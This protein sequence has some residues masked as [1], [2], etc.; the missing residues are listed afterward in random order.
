[1]VFVA[2]M[3]SVS[4]ALGLE[5]RIQTWGADDGLLQNSAADIAQTPEG[6]LIIGSWFGDLVRFDGARF[7]MYDFSGH[8]EW[9]S[10]AISRLLEDDQGNLW[11]GQIERILRYRRG[12]LTAETCA[13]PHKVTIRGWVSPDARRP[14]F[15]LDDGSLL[16][17]DPKASSGLAWKTM[18][19]PAAGSKSVFR[20]SRDGAIWYVRTD[21]LLGRLQAGRCD[22]PAPTAGL[23]SG[24]VR[25]LEKDS[26]GS[27]WAGTERGLARWDSERF[28]DMTPTNGESALTVTRLIPAGDGSMWVA[29]NER[30]RRCRD[31]RWLAEAAGEGSLWKS[32]PDER[33]IQ[34]SRDGGL[35]LARPMGAEILRIDPDGTVKHLTKRD[36]LSGLDISRLF[37][38]SEENLWVGYTRSGL[39]C[40]RPRLFTTVGES[41]GLQNPG[42]TSVSEDR[43]GAIWMGTQSGALECWRAGR[44]RTVDLPMTTD[45]DGA[46]TVCADEAGRVI[47]AR[48]MGVWRQEGE[49]FRLIASATQGV[50]LMLRGGEG[51]VWLASKS[52]IWCLQGD[53]VREMFNAE[54]DGCSPITTLTESADGS[55]WIGTGNGKLAHLVGDQ[56]ELFAPR[57]QH[58]ALWYRAS[59]LDGA[60]G[61]WLGTAGSGLLHFRDGRFARFTTAQGLPSDYIA[62]LVDDGQGSLWMG[63]QAGL[64]RVAKAA[65]ADCAAGRRPDVPWRLF[66]RSD[67]LRTVAI[68]RESKPNCWRARDGRLWF[69]MANSIASVNPAE[70]RSD[71]RPPSVLIEELRVD[72]REI[73]AG[74]AA[75]AERK[76]LDTVP[77]IRPPP[78]GPLTIIPGLHVLEFHYTGLSLTAPESMRFR[79]RLVGCDQDWIEA[80]RERMATYRHLPPG[81][82][83]FEVRAR[84]RD[85]VW[86]DPATLDFKI[87]PHF[88][89]TLWFS[90]GAPT[91]LLALLVGLAGWGIQRKHRQQLVRLEQRQALE[92][93]RARIAQDLH[94]DLGAGLT[95]INLGS[96]LAQDVTTTPT[97]AREYAREIGARARD[98]AA[99]L[100]EIVWAVNP[101]NDTVASLAAYMTQF[102]EQFLKTAR[103][104]VRFSVSNYLPDMPLNSEQ[105]HHLFLVVKEAFNNIVRHAAATEVHLAMTA[106]GGIM[107]I[108]VAD[109]GRGLPFDP[110]RSGGNGL[111]NMRARMQQLGGQCAITGATG[112]G[113]VVAMSLPLNSRSNPS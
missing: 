51:R 57:D 10:R 46:S 4:L 17:K 85:G 19:P 21:G 92:R 105:R 96:S 101:R 111:A 5:Y 11:Y 93:E 112:Q 94:D 79:Y 62:Q 54:A 81:A 60:G 31:R 104:R 25:A 86:S 95:E 41:E 44:C 6:D 83:S 106:D 34:A 32:L 39:A 33:L 70:V 36:G 90:I 23:E 18:T 48:Y 53:T 64:V 43:D 7:S 110:A 3:C 100:D 37:L 55:L 58:G 12:V 1:M 29:A 74:S 52:R 77:A 88:W 27:L 75:T 47:A 108:T 76:A 45:Q 38:D 84:S 87:E 15:L 42:I 8:P 73:S 56:V 28:S 69:V 65:L 72:G 35:W 2:L 49:S 59:L 71:T 63:T 99:A 66:D 14:V 80:G 30:L 98:L 50:T 103:L 20:E 40:I 82:F 24:R 13:I 68:G 67:G 9:Q 26:T 97:E 89:Q 113:T 22:S 91:A 107:R 109:N 102:A 61:L 16:E 78:S